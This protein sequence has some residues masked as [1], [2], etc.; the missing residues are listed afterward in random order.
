M[1]KETTTESPQQFCDGNDNEDYISFLEN[2]SETNQQT[3]TLANETR[4]GMHMNLQLCF[5][6]CINSRQTCYKK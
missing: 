5:C 1:C 2:R 3:R 4:D 6:I